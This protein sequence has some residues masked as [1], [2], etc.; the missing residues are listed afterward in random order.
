MHKRSVQRFFPFTQKRLFWRLKN[1]RDKVVFRVARVIFSQ[2]ETLRRSRGHFSIFFFFKSGFIYTIL[3]AFFL[4]CVEMIERFL[5]SRGWCSV[6]EPPPSID[7]ALQTLTGMQ[8]VFLAV[9]FTAVSVA[10]SAIYTDVPH[11]VRVLLARDRL[12]NFF[13]QF[14]AACTAM[15]LL[16]L[17]FRAVGGTIGRAVLVINLLFGCYSI[18]AVLE[19]LRNSITLFDPA[20]VGRITF[21]DLV[22]AV[23]SASSD[24]FAWKNRNFQR[25]YSN[26]AA[27]SLKTLGMVVEVCVRKKGSGTQPFSDLISDTLS[28]WAAYAV[29]RGRVPFE[30]E[31]Y[32]SEHRYKP[33]LIAPE[34]QVSMAVGTYTTL[35]PEEQK[36][37]NWVEAEFLPIIARALTVVVDRG[38]VSAA[39]RGLIGMGRLMKAL[40]YQLDTTNLT[41]FQNI[42]KDT[43]DRWSK[44]KGTPSIADGREAIGLADTMGLLVIEATLGLGEWA[45]AF[46][47]DVLEKQV[48]T[49]NWADKKAVYQCQMPYGAIGTVDKLQ[50][51]I[52]FEVSVD[53]ERITPAWYIQERL[54]FGL[55]HA[56]KP[57]LTDILSVIEAVFLQDSKQFF[58]SKRYRSAS[59]IVSRGLE[60]IEKF[61]TTM[62]A[63]KR[64]VAGVHTRMKIKDLQW[65]EFVFGEMEKKLIEVRSELLKLFGQLVPELSRLPDDVSLPDFFGECYVKVLEETFASL[66]RDDD[67]AFKE[68]FPVVLDGGLEAF[69]KVR[70]HVSEWEK[71]SAV[72][73]TADVLIDIIDLSSYAKF[74]AEYR[75]N[76]TYWDI[77][78]SSWDNY[79]RT[80]PKPDHLIEY[81]ISLCDFRAGQYE[82]SPRQSA[83]F[84]WEQALMGYLRSEGSLVDICYMPGRKPRSQPHQSKL[85]QMI[86]TT[87]GLSIHWPGPDIFL[88]AYFEKHR[89][90]DEPLSLQDGYHVREALGLSTTHKKSRGGTQ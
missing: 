79:L 60:C 63:V 87:G 38:D 74:F 69:D 73:L 23:R 49:V 17:G 80:H 25:S 24:G 51:E 9:Y 88:I 76:Q 70:K 50:E 8:G 14:V 78:A 68:F 62:A 15:S 53:G 71:T 33:W 82:L 31:W 5:V 67:E 39:Q 16:T 58:T 46:N 40:A 90:S 86:C 41:A 13:L 4:A 3:M 12:G 26:E 2:R 54:H 77:C 83:R 45:R 55:L 11:E 1:F 35:F 81:F 29:F 52:A 30:S 84:R 6:I 18:F 22:Q 48:R 21:D 57:C 10:A 61:S 42:A 64:L 72:T 37:R 34:M 19:V 36:N 56:L 85:V 66:I 47:F 27:R 43:S 59:R 20:R 89:R 75:G 7:Y 65:P 28:T 32:R 44:R